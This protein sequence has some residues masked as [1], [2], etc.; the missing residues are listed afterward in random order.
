VARGQILGFSIGFCSRPYNT[1]ALPCVC[2]IIIIIIIITLD[3]VY[4]AM[5][6]NFETS[7]SSS[8]ECRIA[9]S[10]CQI[11]PTDSDLG[12]QSACRLL[13][14]ISTIAIY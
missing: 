3:N 7:P 1:L 14:S 5:T 13:L 11:K 4:G 6:S 8:D 9:P 10:G 12:C 2:V